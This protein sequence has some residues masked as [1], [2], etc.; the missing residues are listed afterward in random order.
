MICLMTASKQTVAINSGLEAKFLS[1]CN[2]NLFVCLV[3][4]VLKIRK[5]SWNDVNTL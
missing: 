5:I 4:G 1:F 3:N 2:P